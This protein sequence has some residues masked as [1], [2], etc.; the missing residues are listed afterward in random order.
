MPRVFVGKNDDNVKLLLPNQQQWGREMGFREWAR[1]RDTHGHAAQVNAEAKPVEAR[2]IEARRIE[3]AGDKK[4]GAQRGKG[5]GRW[6]SRPVLRQK[7]GRHS[8]SRS[9]SRRW[10]RVF[11][12]PFSPCGRRA[13]DEGAIWLKA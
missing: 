11:F 7:N 8:A 13:G 5:K 9:G 2:R 12:A 1:P 6:Q 4:A 10:C 3:E